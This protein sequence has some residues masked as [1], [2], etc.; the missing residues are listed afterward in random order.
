LEALKTEFRRLAMENHPD[1]GGD[2]E[3][4]KEIN[5]EFDLAYHI[6]QKKA[7][8]KTSNTEPE[9]A[10][11]FRRTFY[12]ENGWEGSRYNPNLR[13]SDIAPIIRG[14]VKD[15]YPTWKFSVV[16]EHFAGGC[17]L[18]V[19]LMEAP[20][21]IFTKED[22]RQK[23]NEEIIQNWEWYYNYMT[24]RARE[25]LTDI[26]ILLNS[27]RYNDSDSRFD[28]YDTNFY[29]HFYIGKRNKPLKIVPRKERIQTS[30][31]AEGARR[32]KA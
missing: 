22:I 16:Q 30:K 18:Y 5:A 29:P 17:G 31:G 14:Y 26:Q 4:M 10:G 20:E 28:Y 13:I 8:V 7:L 32:I 1:R 12:T 21:N 25:V 3:A 15:I 23:S 27:Y 2:S 9:T 6:L 11:E 19:T 24:E